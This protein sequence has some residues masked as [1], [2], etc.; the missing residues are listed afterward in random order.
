ML[1]AI[2]APFAT[3]ASMDGAPSL[4]GWRRWTT[5]GDCTKMPDHERRSREGPHRS[6]TRLQAAQHA[7]AACGVQASPST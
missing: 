2:R 4:C 3:S 1:S 6:Y 5:C 7:A